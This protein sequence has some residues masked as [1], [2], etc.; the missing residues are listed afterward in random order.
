M[1]S[2]KMARWPCR[3]IKETQ[4][5]LA[6]PDENNTHYFQVVT[7]DSRILPLREGPLN[8]H[9]SFQKNTQWQLL[10]NKKNIISM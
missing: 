9:H 8:L 4:C 10:N 1:G 6:Q 5:L 7:V 3:I 2:D